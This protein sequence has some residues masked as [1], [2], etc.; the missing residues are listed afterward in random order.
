[1]KL[2]AVLAGVLL[3]VATLPVVLAGGDP[4]PPLACRGV[5]GTGPVLATIRTVEAG[6]DYTAQA[7]GSS[8]SGAYQML[9]STWR[10]YADLA[11]VDTTT[12][13]RAW[14]AP[15]SAQDAAAAALVQEILDTWHD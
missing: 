10:H 14:Q 15:P 9:D 4:A 7:P 11:G 13:P 6:G 5:A 12:Y 8:A 2:I 3:G 1:M